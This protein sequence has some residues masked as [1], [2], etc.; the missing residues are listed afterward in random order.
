ML[1]IKKKLTNFDFSLKFLGAA[2]PSVQPALIKKVPKR[3]Q[4][5]LIKKV[6]KR[7]NSFFSK[8]AILAPP[9]V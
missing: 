8:L 2:R 9:N 1:H 6:P 7:G 3:V 5:T 4:P